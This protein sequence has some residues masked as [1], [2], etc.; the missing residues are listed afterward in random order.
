MV[1]PSEYARP[2]TPPRFSVAHDTAN[3]RNAAKGEMSRQAAEFELSESRWKGGCSILRG[4]QRPKRDSR[5][6]GNTGY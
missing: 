4:A 3:V 5:G 2:E 1:D 6:L